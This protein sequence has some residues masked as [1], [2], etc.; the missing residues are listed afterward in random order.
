[1]REAIDELMASLRAEGGGTTI[2]I[3]HRLST[4]RNADRIVVLDAGR[5][6][7]QGTHEELLQREGPYAQLIRSQ[8][9]LPTVASKDEAAVVLASVAGAAGASAVSAAPAV[10][11]SV[12]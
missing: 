6:A 12:T 1:V 2:V 11:G 10:N 7:E 5:V 3:A 4:V 8:L 9:A